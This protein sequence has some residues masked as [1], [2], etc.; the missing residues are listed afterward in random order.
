M[1]IDRDVGEL[2]LDVVTYLF[3]SLSVLTRIASSESLY[4]VACHLAG[5]SG[6]RFLTV[7]VRRQAADLWLLVVGLWLLVVGGRRLAASLWLLIAGL[8]LLVARLYTG[9][10][11]VVHQVVNLLALMD[12]DGALAL[13][14]LLNAFSIRLCIGMNAHANTQYYDRQ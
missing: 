10:R 1:D 13:L 5:G 8:W 4:T 12:G 9:C 3:G 6:R 11:G 14:L 2:R 7:S